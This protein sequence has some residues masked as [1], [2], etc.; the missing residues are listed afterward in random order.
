MVRTIDV[1]PTLLDLAGIA[2]PA[3]MDGVSLVPYLNGGA[4]D[5][6][7]AAFNETGIWLTDVPGMPDNHLRYPGLLDLLEV[8]D[9]LSGTLA[10]KR[11]YQEAVITA[12]D[13]MV[14]VGSW[15][16]T[17]QPTTSGPL[18]ALY[19]LSADPDC[20]NDVSTAHPDIVREL[21]DRLTRWM[22]GAA[23]AV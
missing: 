20:R 3:S 23:G 9:K 13:R 18:Y 10:I 2:P 17:Y 16:L 19:D 15:K 4:K 21:Q 1:A 7:L 6:N 12:K 8:P 22:T 14:R 11:E 5:L